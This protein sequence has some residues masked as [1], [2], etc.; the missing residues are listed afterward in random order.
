M[1]E[2]RRMCVRLDLSIGFRMKNLCDTLK[3]RKKG[4]CFLFFFFGHTWLT[5]FS[6]SPL[7]SNRIIDKVKS[8]T[9]G[10]VQTKIESWKFNLIYSNLNEITRNFFPCY[11]T[12]FTLKSRALDIS[13]CYTEKKMEER[14]EKKLVVRNSNPQEKE[15]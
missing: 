5:F 12:L 14:E 11:L 3:R 2:W 9:F 1:K 6:I 4:C 15:N 10:D 13:L 8:H 7:S